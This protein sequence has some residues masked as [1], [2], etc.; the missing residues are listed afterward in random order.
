MYLCS[1][2]ASPLYLHT[3]TSNIFHPLP[4]AWDNA[5]PAFLRRKGQIAL[6]GICTGLQ[7]AN[8]PSMSTRRSPDTLSTVS[9]LNRILVSPHPASGLPSFLNFCSWLD[10]KTLCQS[11]PV[12]PAP[13]WAF[14]TLRCTSSPGSDER[15]GSAVTSFWPFCIWLPPALGLKRLQD[16][17]PYSMN[18]P[19]CWE[20]ARD[21]QMF[22]RTLKTIFQL[23]SPLFNRKTI[24]LLNLSHGLIFYTLSQRNLT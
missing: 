12:S 22:P 21:S 9:L 15:H 3:Y 10:Y 17:L 20:E 18:F 19:I 16:V 1:T 7:N 11:L 13:C 8:H 14:R 2:S 5:S 6:Q 23:A 4:A 24:R